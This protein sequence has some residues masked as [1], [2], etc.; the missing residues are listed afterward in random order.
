[1]AAVFVGLPFAM[2]ATQAPGIALTLALLLA[3]MPVVYARLDR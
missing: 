2:L 3:A 1:M